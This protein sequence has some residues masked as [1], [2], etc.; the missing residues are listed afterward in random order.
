MVGLL[1]SQGLEYGQHYL[2][3]P[4]RHDRSLNPLG[5]GLL[6]GGV[7]SVIAFYSPLSLVPI[8][9]NNNH[10]FNLEH[11]VLFKLRLRMIESI[12]TRVA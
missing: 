10:Y 11:Y 1:I 8:L 9:W 5:T 12:A 7:L 6:H 4:Q 3:D 2:M